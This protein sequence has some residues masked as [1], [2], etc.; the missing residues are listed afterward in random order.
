MNLLFHRIIHHIHYYTLYIQDNVHINYILKLTSR[1][2]AFQ[3]VHSN[4]PYPTRSP[5]GNYHAHYRTGLRYCPVQMCPGLCQEYWAVSPDGIYMV[6]VVTMVTIITHHVPREAP[7]G[8]M[9]IFRLVYVVV[10]NEGVEV[11]IRNVGL[12]DLKNGQF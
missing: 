7:H 10:Q 6:T 11:N 12:Y 2:F 9:S 3:T 8:C 4:L 5:R 1:G